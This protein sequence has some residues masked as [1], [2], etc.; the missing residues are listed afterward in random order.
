[1]AIQTRLDGT[2]IYR[3][4]A[5]HFLGSSGILRLFP[6]LSWGFHGKPLIH[7]FLSPIPQIQTQKRDLRKKIYV[8]TDCLEVKSLNSY[9]GIFG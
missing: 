6:F 1:M 9:F 8:L 2:A 3:G 5:P 7:D 4:S